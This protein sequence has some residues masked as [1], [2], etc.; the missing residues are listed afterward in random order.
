MKSGVPRK[1][2]LFNFCGL[3]VSFQGPLTKGHAPST[4]HLLRVTTGGGENWDTITSVVHFNRS[5]ATKSVSKLLIT[6]LADRLSIR[7]IVS[8]VHITEFLYVQIRREYLVKF[9]LP[10]P[11]HFETVYT[12]KSGYRQ[13]GQRDGGRSHTGTDVSVRLVPVA[14]RG[15]ES[16]L[17][18]H[19]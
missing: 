3:V 13:V 5:E 18:T 11:T 12:G 6:K 15:Q 7:C 4:S 8:L 17:S 2:T 14:V 10:D 1:S 9:R 16:S 19:V